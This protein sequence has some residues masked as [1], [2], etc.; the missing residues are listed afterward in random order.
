[1]DIVLPIL[2]SSLLREKIY[3]RIGFQIRPFAKLHFAFFVSPPYTHFILLVRHSSAVGSAAPQIA[4]QT[5]VAALPVPLVPPLHPAA[6][7]AG[8]GNSGNTADAGYRDGDTATLR[9]WLPSSL[10]P[11]AL[12]ASCGG[13]IAHLSTFPPSIL[14]RLL[15]EPGLRVQGCL[16]GRNEGEQSPGREGTRDGR[17][18]GHPDNTSRRQE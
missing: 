12:A 11:A 10:T 14:L 6:A 5:T 1:M 9:L 8:I 16:H 15:H 2:T 18:E 7:L 4:K 13:S 3:R 17:G